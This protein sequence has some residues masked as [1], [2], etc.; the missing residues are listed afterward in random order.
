[1]C[2]TGDIDGNSGLSRVVIMMKI[3]V[4]FVRSKL[5]CLICAVA[6]TKKQKNYVSKFNAEKNN[7]LLSSVPHV[8]HLVLY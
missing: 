2:G 4:C 8:R 5:C 6:L 3:N 7:F 1:M